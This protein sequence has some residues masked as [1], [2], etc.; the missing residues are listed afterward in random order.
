MEIILA[1]TSKLGMKGV[2]LSVVIC[3]DDT[4]CL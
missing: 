1:T 3:E 2:G 4:V